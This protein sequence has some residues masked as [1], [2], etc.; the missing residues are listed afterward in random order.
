MSITDPSANSGPPPIRPATGG[1][2]PAVHP[3]AIEQ[4]GKPLSD[5][6]K[7]EILARA[8]QLQDTGTSFEE[9]KG[10]VDSELEDHGMQLP[11][12]SSRSGQFIDTYS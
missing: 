9:V 1:E 3:S 8:Q 2:G 11:E 5:D 7:D 10:F 12:G 4:S 6:V